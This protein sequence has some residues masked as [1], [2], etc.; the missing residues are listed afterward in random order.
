[1]AEAKMGT[2]PGTDMRRRTNMEKKTMMENYTRAAYEKGVFAGAWL[3]AENGEIVTKGAVGFHDPAGRLP[4]QE[5]SI[6]DIG[7][8]SKQFTAAAIMLLRR[9][10]LLDLE[11]EITKF[12]PEIPFK[13]ITIRHLLTHT[14]GLPDCF[15]WIIRTAKTEHTI[16]DNGVVLRFLTESGKTPDFAPGEQWAYSNTGYALLA[17]IAAKVSGIPFAELLQKKLFEPAGMTSTRLCHRIRDGLAIE[18]LAEGLCY[19]NGGWVAAQD[20]AW[21]DVAISL[22]GSEGDGFVKSNIFDLLAWDRALR[23][24][25]ILT[26][27]EQALM[28]TPALLN[29]GE[30]GGPGYGFGWVILDQPGLGRIALHNGG[31][32]GYKSWYV[33]FLDADRV[34][35][36]LCARYGLDD[37]AAD[38][39]FNGLIPLALGYEQETVPLTEE[40]A[41]ANPNRSGWDS[42][43][44]EYETEGTGY[45]VEKVYLEHGDL[46]VAI[47]D[48]ESGRRFA[49]RMYPFGENTFGIRESSDDI[50]FEDGCL[51]FGDNSCKKL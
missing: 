39:F 33:R 7:S 32:P 40:L 35:V 15:A 45:L 28:Y 29:N 24:E 47:F 41:V 49:A 22:D 4:M 27:E 38:S 21:K 31:L 3:L 6:F 25:T 11:D 14:G 46:F 13:G 2:A 51:T 34:L 10:G 42:F 37:R 19:E 9:D 16:P 18:N 17:E 1:M 8:V 43:C 44:G 50:V 20:S 5:D 23:N 36:A 12:F 26:K 48:T 30:I